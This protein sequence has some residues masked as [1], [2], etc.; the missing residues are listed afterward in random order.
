M[1]TANVRKAQRL[2]EIPPDGSEPPEELIDLVASAF[3]APL[4]LYRAVLRCVIIDGVDVS[5]TKYR[6]WIWDLHIAFS[7]GDFTVFGKR[8]VRFVSNDKMI[9]KA[10]HAVGLGG[11]VSS[12]EEYSTALRSPAS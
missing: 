1:A 12:F 3:R 4:E 10:A 9:L 11:L 7:I 2:L 5:R 8:P 6:N